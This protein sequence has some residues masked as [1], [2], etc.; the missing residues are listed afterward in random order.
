MLV[1]Y[2]SRR[3]IVR[4]R[5]ALLS[6]PYLKFVDDDPGV[7]RK[8]K[9]HRNKKLK[10]PVPMADQQHNADEIEYSHKHSCYA[11]KLPHQSINPHYN[12]DIK[13]TVSQK[14]CYFITQLMRI[15]G[16]H[17][18]ALYKSTFTYLLTYLLTYLSL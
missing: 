18:I 17:V 9:Q 1:S 8:F 10:T 7:G 4:K 3:Q 5:L 14:T 2:F 11:K 6:M 16:F 13:F 15:R 12:N